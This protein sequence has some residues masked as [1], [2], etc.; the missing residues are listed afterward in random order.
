[1]RERGHEVITAPIRENDGLGDAIAAA[2]GQADVVMVGGG[3]GTLIRAVEGLRAAGLPLAILPLGTTNELART[4]QIPTGIVQACALVDDGVPRP[5]DVGCVNGVWFFNEAS[6]GLSTH[7][8]REQTGAVKSRWGMLSIPIAT[9]RALRYLRP[10]RLEVESS[11]GNRV[12]RTV[13]LTVAN[14]YR[15]GGIVENPDAAIDDGMLDLYTID[16]MHWWDAFAVIVA[17]ARR[18]FPQAHNVTTLRAPAFA[19]RS[20]RPHR[21]FADGEPATWTPAEFTVVPHAVQVLV[22]R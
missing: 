12:F 10:H 14:S 22:P 3:D 11:A 4:L 15:F 6:I 17:V 7:V 5:I 19:V 8:A 2:R 20:R 9:V 18:R 1:M 21:I 13:Q 16:L